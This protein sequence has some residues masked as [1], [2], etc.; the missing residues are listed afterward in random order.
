MFDF[1]FCLLKCLLALFLHTFVPLSVNHIHCCWQ[2][3][4]LSS[5][6]FPFFSVTSISWFFQCQPWQKAWF[7]YDNTICQVLYRLTSKSCDVLFLNTFSF[8]RYA[9]QPVLELESPLDFGTVVRNSKVLSK[10]IS[11]YNHGSLAGMFKIKYSGNE[12]F[13]I[14][15]LQGIV[16][17]KSVQTIKVS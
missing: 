16:K 3:T 8:S 13:T 10:E 6:T 7:K 17:P 4:W 15:P 11:L 2:K 1:T 9:P 14:F 12:P 5:C